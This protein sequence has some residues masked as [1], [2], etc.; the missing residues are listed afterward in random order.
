LPPIFDYGNK[1]GFCAHKKNYKNNMQAYK[2]GSKSLLKH[3]TKEHAYL[4]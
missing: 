4:T 3:L 2:I 1:R